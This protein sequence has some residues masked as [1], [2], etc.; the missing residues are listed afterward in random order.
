MI[1]ALNAGLLGSQSATL[2][3]SLRHHTPGA[4]RIFG[5]K[6]GAA[7]QVHAAASGRTQMFD[8]FSFDG[9]L[10]QPGFERGSST[11][12]QSVELMAPGV[13]L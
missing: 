2:L 6:S 9:G 12:E 8:W 1:V 4:A 7:L 3:G 10:L 13:T 11:G 5:T